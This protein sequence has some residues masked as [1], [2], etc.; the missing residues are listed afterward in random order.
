MTKSYQ[1]TRIAE[2]PDY[3]HCPK[4]KNSCAELCKKYPDGIDDDYIA[5][6]LL[7]DVKEVKEIYERA[8]VKLRSM[9]MNVRR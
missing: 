2:D 8:V 6:V 4:M 1:G 9:I 3:I 5:R 7:I